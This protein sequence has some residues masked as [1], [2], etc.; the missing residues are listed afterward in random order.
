MADAG[1]FAKMVPGFDF[2]QG[3]VKNAGSALPNMGQWVAPTLNPEELEKRIEELRTVQFWLEQN[4]RMM[5]ATIQALEVQRMTLSTLKSMNVSMGE[6]RDAMTLKTPGAQAAAEELDEDEDEDE[7]DEEA[8]APP[9]AAASSAASSA[10]APAGVVD[11]MQWWGALTKQ[12]TQ[13]A[14]NTMKES[15]TDAAKNLAGAMVKQSFEAANETL[16]K[17]VSVPAAVAQ[18]AASA[19][20]AAAG[21]AAP[22]KAASAAAGKPAAKKPASKSA[23]KT[24][25][26]KTTAAK[27]ATKPRR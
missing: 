25:A 7:D 6:L 17:A 3:L 5:G 16:K 26:S 1:G 10:D 23:S 27:R 4:A 13:L 12:F 14:A 22:R 24:A 21:R 8:A 2:L 19:A 15:A 9:A 18:K 11:P 20:T